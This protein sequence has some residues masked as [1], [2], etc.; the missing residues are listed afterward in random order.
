MPIHPMYDSDSLFVISF[1]DTTRLF[2]MGPNGIPN[3][4]QWDP[5]GCQGEP[6]H[7]DS[8]GIPKGTMPQRFQRESTGNHPTAIPRYANGN[9][10]TAIQK[11]CQWEPSHSDSKGIAK[12]TTHNKLSKIVVQPAYCDEVLRSTTCYLFDPKAD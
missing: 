3:G 1:R 10:P 12:G 5:R 4:T 6:F 2:L 8:K 9:G 7:S 11:G